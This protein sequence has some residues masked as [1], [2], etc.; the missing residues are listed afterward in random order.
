MPEAKS[1]EADVILDWIQTE[2]SLQIVTSCYA[3]WLTEKMSAR[4]W[5]MIVVKFMSFS[6]FLLASTTGLYFAFCAVIDGVQYKTGIGIT[7]KEARLN[8]A[9]LAFQ[10]LLPTLESL[11]SALPEASC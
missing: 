7:K 4:C 6:C 8:A 10:D 5:G 11:K 2:G 3:Q 9:E 1:L